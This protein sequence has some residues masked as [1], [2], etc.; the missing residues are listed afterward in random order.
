MVEAYAGAGRDDSMTSFQASLIVL[1][2]LGI[3]GNITLMVLTLVEVNK[4]LARLV[5]LEELS[6]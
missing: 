2:L 3:L 5:E 6:K 1:V 4:A